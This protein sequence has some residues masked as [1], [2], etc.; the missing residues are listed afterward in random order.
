MY[1]IEI[2]LE[3][4]YTDTQHN[5]IDDKNIA[6]KDGF[7]TFVDENN[8]ICSYNVDKIVRYAT[9][10]VKTEVETEEK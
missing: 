2:I 8:I 5:I 1:S 4:G 6:I 3:K 7:L 10:E 9:I